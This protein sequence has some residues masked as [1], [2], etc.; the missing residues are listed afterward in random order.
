[1]NINI[2]KDGTS[3]FTRD[4][5]V[6]GNR[7]TE[8]LQ[9]EFGLTYEDAE[10]VKRGESVDGADRDQITAI[11]A[12]VT[13]DI[14]A[15]TQRSLDFFRSTTGSEQVSR[16]LVS[17]GCARI[18]NFTHVLAERIEIPVEITNPFKNIK[19]DP[20]KFNASFLEET[21]PQSAVAVGLAIRR[22]GDR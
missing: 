8:A 9:R 6:G 10:K 20:K 15:E 19:V 11:M 13:E 16:V 2:L 21:G 14:V 17:G 3:I 22:P 18:G 4:I 1:M 12:Q 5:T 7:Y